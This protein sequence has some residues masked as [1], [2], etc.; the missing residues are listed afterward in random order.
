MGKLIFLGIL[1]AMNFRTE[2]QMQG[3]KCKV[4]LPLWGQR[5]WQCENW[6]NLSVGWRISEGGS[7]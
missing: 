1:L 2:V 6:G 7:C 3:G 4:V 5:M